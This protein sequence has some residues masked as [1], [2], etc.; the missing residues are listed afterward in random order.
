MTDEIKR[1]LP[2]KLNL[3]M[4]ADGNPV[5]PPAADPPKDPEPPKKIELTQEE[6]DAKIAERLARERKKFADYDD[7][8]TKLATLEQA[9]EERKKAAM[10]EKERLE[11]EKADAERKAQEAADERDKAL[12]A[13]NQRLVK[14]EFK[15]LARELGIRTD[16]LEDAY[17]L[18]DL[19]GVKVDDD[20]N[21]EGVKDVIEALVAAKPYLAEQKKQ[22]RQIGD[23][24]N[25][26]PGD[27]IKTLEQQLEDAKKR[28]D[29]S[30]VIEIS[31]K[32]KTALSK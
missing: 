7:V 14:A 6:F 11:S 28:K 2:H 5:D 32:I 13:A 31:N 23:P 16:A 30:K 12:T 18:A 10:S 26:P 15:A 8:K 3:Q 17:K 27:E 19:A 1:G 22:P 24:N 21:V 20:G 29:F 25:P 9:E 4:F